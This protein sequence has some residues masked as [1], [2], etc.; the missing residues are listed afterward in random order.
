MQRAG[1]TDSS[2]DCSLV[3]RLGRPVHII[4]GE[5][6]NI[7]I[8]TELDLFLAEQ[9]LRVSVKEGLTES[10]SLK[11][12]TF[13]IT[14][15]TGGIGEALSQLLLA[16]GAIPIP[17]SRE[18]KGYSADL[19]IPSLV[20]KV[21][22]EIYSKHGPLDGLINGVGLLKSKPLS[23]LSAEE[24]EQMIATNLTSAIYSCKYAHIKP[25]GHIINIASSSYLRGRADSTIYSS[26]KAALVNF[27]QGLA[28][29][30]PELLI[31]ALIPQRTHT[32]MRVQNFP[33]EPVETLLH[34]DE[35]A[36]EILSLL[37]Q[38]RLTGT[39]A[40]VRKKCVA[41]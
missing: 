38:T 5:E 1:I 40:Q 11:G 30:R 19:T 33:G 41:K 3:I 15:G 16:E 9:L 27:S 7:K 26:A 29:E 36:K 39:T 6:S 31:N 25:L 10:V 18:S 23:A 13:A 32:Q 37:K 34:P 35:V 22:D 24:I 4:F 8:T 21:F 28:E 20:E 17:I 14:G 2:D 12:K